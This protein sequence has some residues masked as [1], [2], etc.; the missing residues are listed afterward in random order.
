MSISPHAQESLIP[1][2]ID[3]IVY[4][5]IDRESIVAITDRGGRIT[6]CNAKFCELSGY[7]Q[8]ELLG[9][10]HRLLKSGTHPDGFFQGMWTTI[11]A[12]RYWRGEICN[13]A[14]SGRLYW[15]E[16][17]IAPIVSG[18]EVTGFLSIRTD[19]TSRKAAQ[20]ELARIRQ[21]EEAEARF[22]ALGRMSDG[23]LHDVA[24]VLTGMM[25]LVEEQP[26]PQ[27]DAHLRE[28]VLRMSE[29]TSLLR[30]YSS[31]KPVSTE[32]VP[33]NTI[34]RSAAALVRYRRGAPKDLRIA[35]HTLGTE[36]VTVK[37]NRA[38]LF[39]VVLNLLVNAIEALHGI[40]KPLIEIETVQSVNDTVV[41][42][43]DN[44]P[45]IPPEVTAALFDPY[46]STKGRGRGLGLSL[47]KKIAR[48]HGGDLLFEKRAQHGA[49]FAL[50]LPG[51]S[52]RASA[53][54]SRSGPAPGPRWLILAEEDPAVRA[55]IERAATRCGLEVI[56]PQDPMDLLAIL[57]RMRELADAVVLDCPSW[58][59]GAGLFSCLQDI[60][61]EVP[62][63]LTTAKHPEGIVQFS[64]GQALSIPAPFSEETFVK[65]LDTLPRMPRP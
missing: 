27:R 28:A 20:A 58:N 6:Y 59:S 35:E 53:P 2:G 63:I 4:R 64:W 42:V 55:V 3:Q 45:G 17:V 41:Y 23:I 12:G 48:A 33:I 47:A 14:K 40:E 1:D 38:Q 39:E 29:L 61:P 32:E 31:G 18:N 65:A 49:C 11:T 5:T 15:V 60:A 54:I 44:G 26:G 37:G 7:T 62:L 10:D 19:I 46:V 51:V 52:A 21:I 56:V 9:Q 25:G 30:D 57:H 50:H 22:A 43:R 16:T 24:N 34:V 36:G 13:R 8:A